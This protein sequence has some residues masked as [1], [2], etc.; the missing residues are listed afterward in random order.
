MLGGTPGGLR[1]LWLDRHNPV[2][3]GTLGD[4]TEALEG[5]DLVVLQHL[6]LTE[7]ARYAHVVL[8]VVAHGEEEVTFT[9]TERRIQLA[10]KVI[11][12]PDRPIPGWRQIVQVAGRL[13]AAWEYRSTAEVMD[14]IRQ[15][16]PDY[17][18][19][20]YENLAQGIRPPVALHQGPAPGHPELL[21]GCGGPFRLMLAERP[22]ASLADGGVSLRAHLRA[23]ALLLAPERARPAQRD[24]EARV[25]DPPPR[26]PRGIRG[27]ERG[28]RLGAPA[29]ATGP[30][31]GSSRRSGSAETVRPGHRRGEAAGSI[32]VPYFLH[33]FVKRI[34]GGREWLR[35]YS[36]SRQVH[37]RVEA[38]E[39]CW[40]RRCGAEDLGELVDLLRRDQEVVAPFRRTRP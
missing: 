21:A 31:S 37:V 38:A 22:A 16:I 13:G 29:C 9:S 23:L 25:R 32:F 24:P 2:V 18:A 1:A 6:F 14:E 3:T 40:A 30:A 7:T 20:S 19:A 36:G 17:E 5:L 26:L 10:R 8:P 35:E 27:G 4:P 39:P 11:D 34:R 28:G 15:A 33:D 12:P